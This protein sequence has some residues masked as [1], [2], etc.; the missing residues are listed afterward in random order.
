MLYFI[1]AWYDEN[2]W[3][4]REEV[5]YRPKTSMEADDTAKEIQL[6]YRRNLCPL[7]IIL[8]SS[9]PNFRHFLHRL[10]LIHVEY[11]SIFDAMQCIRGKQLNSFSYYD[12]AWPE[13]TEFHLTPFA[14]IASLHGERIA[15]IQ[16]G[17]GGNLI[18]IERYE[19]G[20][21]VSEISYDD[22]GFI[23]S[24]RTLDQGKVI[25]ED[26][27]DNMGK[28]RF[29]LLSGGRVEINSDLPFYELE[30]GS[31]RIQKSYQKLQYASLEDVIGE[32]FSS[33]LEQL[34]AESIFCIANHDRHAALLQ[35]ALKK[36]KTIVTVYE[37]RK[38][39]CNSQVAMDFLAGA[40]QIITDSE[41]NEKIVR[42]TLIRKGIPED[43][44]GHRIKRISPFS[45]RHETSLCQTLPVKNL[46]LPVDLLSESD[47][48][49][50]I[51]Q[52]AFFLKTHPSVRVHLFTR[53]AEYW[54]EERIL[55]RVEE[56]LSKA[57]FPPEWSIQEDSSAENRTEEGGSSQ[58]FFADV[59]RDS[60]SIH[61]CMLLQRVLVD[62]SKRPDQ[63][64]QVSAVSLG[65]PQICKG[66]TVF[67]E[68][69][70]NGI[71]LKKMEDLPS[72]L[73]YYLDQLSH[74]NDAR[75]LAYRLGERYSSED[76]EKSW[77]EVIAGLD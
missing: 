6:F 44:F 52:L 3:R 7:K 57:S 36:R 47:F 42:Q 19:E 20:K 56:I 48:Q 8:L 30:T 55:N 16:F 49:E 53:S 34:D 13:G 2:Q 59:C 14:A 64:L 15:L 12:L 67:L 75:V 60:M 18:R 65:I 22:R 32:V 70:Q 24:I 73:S 40:D 63:F 11:W 21:E 76:I 10:G 77:K 35:K 27:L 45:V 61:R 66:K 43:F 38:K 9:A 50:A 46:L 41:E 58:K 17:E 72:A 71:L 4:E 31:R 69:G 23:S 28:V 5:W 37:A 39:V 33:Y 25:R 74:W 29:S 62:L 51:L 26:F 54:A 68:D 1:P